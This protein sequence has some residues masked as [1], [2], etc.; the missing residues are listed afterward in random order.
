MQDLVSNHLAALKKEDEKVQESISKSDTAADILKE[1]KDIAFDNA[2][3]LF[4][5]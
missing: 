5:P 3:S 1:A 2:V 4:G